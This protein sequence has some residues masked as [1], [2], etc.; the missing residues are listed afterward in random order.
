MSLLVNKGTNGRWKEVFSEEELQLY[1]D[2]CERVLT[3]DCVH[4]LE[5]GQMP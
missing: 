2:T 4:W 5:T 1:H 3:P